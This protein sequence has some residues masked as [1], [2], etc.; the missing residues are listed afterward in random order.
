MHFSLKFS[1]RNSEAHGMMALCFRGGE[2]EQWAI[3]VLGIN[4][5]KGGDMATRWR[6]C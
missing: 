1:G 5:G 4:V 3:Y 6:T 2:L